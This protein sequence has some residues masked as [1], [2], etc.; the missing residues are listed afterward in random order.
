MRLETFTR[1]IPCPYVPLLPTPVCSWQALCS[2][3]KKISQALAVANFV[4]YQKDN[5]MNETAIVPARILCLEDDPLDQELLETALRRDGLVCE[6]VSVQTEQ[7]FESALQRNPF[8]LIISDFSLPGYGG[9]QALASAKNLR[10]ETPFIFVSGTIGEERA[11]ESLKNG[12]ADYILKNRRERLVPAVRRALRDGRARAERLQAEQ[13][14]RI[15]AAALEASANGILITDARGVIL[16]A[17]RAFCVSSGYAPEEVLGRTPAFIKSDEHEPGFYEDLLKTI[18]S[19][20][21]WHNE[22]TSRRKDG[23]LYDEEV[24]ITPVRGTDGAITHF[25]AVTQDVTRR[26]QLEAQLRQA[27]KMEAVG[28]LAGGVAHDFNNLLAVIQGNAE[29]A[30]LH[31]GALSENIREHLTQITATSARAAN[32]TRQ[33]LAFGRKQAMRPEAVGVNDVI[34]NLTKMLERIVSEDIALQCVY[35]RHPLFVHADAGMLEQILLNLVVNA[36]DAMPRGGQLVITTKKVYVD[37]K[38]ALAH[39]EARAGEFVCLKVRDTGCGIPAAQLPR[40]FEPFFTTK[41]V[42]KGTGLGLSTVYGIVKQHLGWLDVSSRVGAGTVFRIFLPAIEPPVSAALPPEPE[43]AAALRGGSER[44]LV[45][46]DDPAVRLMTRRILNQHGYHVIEA[47][48][49]REALEIWQCQGGGIDLLLTDMIM[50]D[51]VNGRELAQ[52]LRDQRPTLKT[53][54]VSGYSSNIAGKDTDFWRRNDDPF[55]QKPFHAHELID[56]VR[57]CLD[58]IA[59]A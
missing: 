16:S 31:D 52:K 3:W 35:D 23:V 27:Q 4:F 20:R 46:E 40:I 56:T 44:I 9:M 18:L 5:P 14:T 34:G 15:Q 33:L 1:P 54:F 39:P 51:G 12:A 41:E 29:M 19:G 10:A 8:D 45:V 43:P 32:L 22:L 2:K 7:D 57:R 47:A 30:L 28:Q 6:F 38:Y 11:V 13:Q 25:I 48:S 53:V 50:P 37:A 55:I 42:G 36:R 26:K 21:V 49:G 24:T 58:E 59:D 17:N